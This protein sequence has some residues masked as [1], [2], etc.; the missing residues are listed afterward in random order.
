MKLIDRILLA[1][2]VA[3]G[4]GSL[5]GTAAF[6][7]DRIAVGGI[8]YARDSEY[9]QQV[10]KGMQAAAKEGGADLQVALNRRQLTT[11]AQVI[12][13]FMTRGVKVIVMP[14]LDRE[15]S[16]SAARLAHSQG[17]M[18][19]DYDAPLADASIA[20]HTIGVDSRDLAAEVGRKM[21]S[22]IDGKLGGSAKVGLI[23]VPPTN[24][25]MKAR[26]TG[27]QDGLGDKGVTIVSDVAA[28]TPEQGASAFENILQRTPDTKVVW[29][30]NAGSLAGAASTAQRM[31]SDTALF[32][33]DMSQELARM[34]LDPTSHLEAVSD[35][36]PYQIGYTAVQ[37][38]LKDLA[39]EKQ[40]RNVTVP[41]RLYSRDD[42]AG[43]K[44][45][46]ER[47]AAPAK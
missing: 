38:A 24:P 26:R 20:S 12:D 37:T 28:S 19:V 8:I 34:L 32:G 6:A 46:L 43:V 7:K 39:G 10:E 5:G 33:I 18:I 47:T 29:C 35:Q 17:I 40:P 16:V 36:Q 14:P 9:W 30:A 27:V 44:E 22:Y 41:V 23:T 21:R 13:D 1:S 4:L 11:E 2:V 31:K 42:P 45:Y 3:L 15:A 25:N